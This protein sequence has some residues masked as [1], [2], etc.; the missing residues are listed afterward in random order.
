MTLNLP[1]L[2]QARET[3]SLLEH[4]CKAKQ[5]QSGRAQQ[6]NSYVI[7]MSLEPILIEDSN[8]QN[9]IVFRN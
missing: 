6:N 7:A 9:N 5:N 8:E 2:S 1:F 4:K 3:F